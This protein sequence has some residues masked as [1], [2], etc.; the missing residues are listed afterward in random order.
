MHG[1]L[2]AISERSEQEIALLLRRLAESERRRTELLSSRRLDGSQGRQQ[3]E[4]LERQ[5]ETDRR[6]LRHAREFI[7]DLLDD[8]PPR[9]VCRLGLAC[10]SPSTN[11]TS[12]VARP[13]AQAGEETP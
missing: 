11:L 5:R 4:N 13:V 10:I 3:L 6:K 7:K 1:R 8:M 9:Q 2:A 12:R